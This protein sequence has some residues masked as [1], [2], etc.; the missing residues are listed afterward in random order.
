MKLPVSWLSDWIEHRL[1]GDSLAQRLTMLGLEVDAMAPVGA[2][3]AG[4]VVGRV[5]EVRPHPNADRLSLCRVDVG[6]NEPLEIVCGAR[7]V[8]AGGLYPTAL[9]GA[10]LPGG[11][12]IRTSRIRGELS[13]GM[14]CSGSELGLETT[15]EGL[16]DL[17]SDATPGEDA[18]AAL[19]LDDLVMDINVTPN[20]A[21]CFSVLGVARELAA[22][23]AGAA[24]EPETGPVPPSHTDTLPVHV[25]HPADCPRFLGRVVRAVRGDART[26]LWMKERL[27]RSGV[28]PI[29]PVVDVTNFVMLELGQPMHA[30]DLARLCGG[31]QVRRAVAG[32]T[33]A[34]LDG[35]T[36]EAASDV[37]VIADDSGAIGLAGIMGG[38]GTAVTTATCAVFL[39]CAFFSTAAIAGRARRYGL[40]TDASVR[41]ERGVDPT[42]QATAMER[43]TALIIEIAGGEAGPV[44]SV[45]APGEIP[46][47]HAIGLRRQ[48]LGQVLGVSIPDG[49]VAQILRRLRMSLA[50]TGDGWMVTPPPARFD[51]EREEDLIEEVARV[52]GYDQIPAQPERVTV[53]P[54]PAGET[55]D[56]VAELASAL[57]ARGYQEAITYSFISPELGGLFALDDS[58]QLTLD[59]PI[60]ADLSG[61]RQSL[62]PGLVNAVRNNLHRQQTRVRLFEI[63][64]RFVAASAGDHR[65]EPCIT[66]VAVGARLPEQWAVPGAAVD[67]FDVK[68]DVEALLALA[69]LQDRASFEAAAHPALHPGRSARVTADGRVIG[70]VGEIHPGLATRLE[71]PPAILFELAIGTLAQRPPPACQPLSVFPSVRRDMAV[72]VGR[73]VPAS[74]LLARVRSAAPSVLREAFIF[75]IYTGQQVGDNEK[76]IAIGLILQDTS[77]TLTDEDINDVLET[78]RAALGR[79]FQARIR[80]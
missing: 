14:L 35:Q 76:S 66:A 80:E 6:R 63:G 23:G 43:A 20:R 17:D 22:S 74:A 5:L 30:Y 60:S 42:L 65:E 32:E 47:R 48:R 40:H 38:A 15:A 72:L 77:R 71:M 70:W 9:E 44:S 3:V 56:V 8:R 46:A 45:A 79:E 11:L 18:S 10:Q 2:R 50:D 34:L 51:V 26:P 39:E 78:V 13:S 52:F 68:A 25:S 73:Q 24:R 19:G 67:F 37:L 12:V 49:E 27:R 62:W 69:G 54:A 55:P 29:H 36:I 16:L 1:D 57:M 33:L 31:I 4:L 7:N 21:D 59:N 41:F 61:M 28:R 64:S 58:P 53:R 75:D